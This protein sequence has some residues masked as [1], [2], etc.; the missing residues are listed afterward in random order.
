MLDFDDPGDIGVYVTRQY[1]AA[2]E[3]A[4]LAGQ[5]MKGAELAT[6]FA[7][8]RPNDLVWNY[9]V[10][11]YLKGQTPPLSTCC[12][13]MPT[14]PTF[15]AD[16]RVLPARVLSREQAP[17]APRPSMLGE[18]IDLSSIK[19]PAHVVATRDDHIVPWR[20]AYRTGAPGRRD[21]VHA[22]RI[23]SHRRHREPGR[24]GK[25]DHWT[26]P[27]PATMPTTGCPCRG[28][29]GSWWTTGARGSR[30]T[31]APS[32][33]VARHRQCRS[34]RSARRPAVR[35]EQVG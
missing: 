17:R 19:V 32:L 15:R 7:T 25:R 20:T 14:R 3:P 21:D 34:R 5:R 23:G 31:P 13:G 6:A 10:G 22:R 30:R 2:R 11:N 9:V 29:A 16:V 8:L 35:H 28:V 33:L 1:L 24:G 27:R 4:L 18:R 12:T 26:N